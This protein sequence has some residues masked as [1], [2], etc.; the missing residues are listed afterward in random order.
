MQSDIEAGFIGV[1]H[2]A[3]K[4]ALSTRT[5]W[6]IVERGELPVKRIGRRTVI[7]LADVRKWLGDE[8]PTPGANATNLSRQ[9][10]DRPAMR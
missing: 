9:F 1:A 7:P 3:E 6:R 8:T 2:L 10:M 5:V 4:L